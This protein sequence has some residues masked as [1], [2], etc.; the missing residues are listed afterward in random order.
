MKSYVSERPAVIPRPAHFVH[1]VLARPAMNTK[2]APEPTMRSGTHR[3]RPWRAYR[4]LGKRS[5]LVW[6]PR[7]W[8]LN[9][10]EPMRTSATGRDSLDGRRSLTWTYETERGGEDR[11]RL[12]HNPEV[13][14]S[15]P[16]PATSGNDPRGATSGVIFM[17]DGHVFGHISLTY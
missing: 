6:W 14:G 1:L 17:P 8:P 10:V 12:A 15:N 13:A 5:W 3:A 4:A 7:I 9:T 16:V 11:D 2:S